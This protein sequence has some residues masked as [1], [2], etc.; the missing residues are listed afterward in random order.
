MKSAAM[1][2]RLGT[3]FDVPVVFMV[4]TSIQ[5]NGVR[6]RLDKRSA[7]SADWECRLEWRNFFYFLNAS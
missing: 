6:A 1:T 7:E 3:V 5:F 4:I 2:T